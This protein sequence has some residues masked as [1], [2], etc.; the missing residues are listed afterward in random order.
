MF[1]AVALADLLC[2]TSSRAALAMPY[3]MAGDFLHHRF[4]TVE[5]LTT[6]I[7]CP[8]SMAFACHGWF[9]L[10][11]SHDKY[12]TLRVLTANEYYNTCRGMAEI[13]TI[14]SS[15]QLYE[16]SIDT[17]RLVTPLST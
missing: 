6:M 13:P 14:R 2:D 11:L 1:L 16:S 3:L 8:N 10:Y 4:T 17:F 15:R 5:M 9:G 12:R 7:G